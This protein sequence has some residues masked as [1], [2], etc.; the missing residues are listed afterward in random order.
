[1]DTAWADA[2]GKPLVMSAALGRGRILR[3]QRQLGSQAMPELLEPD[4]AARLASLLAQPPPAPTRVAARNIAPT[5]D[6][7]TY[8]P[9]AQDLRPWLA[10]LIAAVFFVVRLLA[11]GRRVRVTA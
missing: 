8:T 11:S 3:L 10:L 5:A 4:F 6:G 7:P 2:V 1:M 9:P